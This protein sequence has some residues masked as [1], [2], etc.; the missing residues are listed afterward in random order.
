MAENKTGELALGD[1]LSEFIPL[2]YRHFL[3]AFHERGELNLTKSQNKALMIMEHR[4][5]V[6]SSEL[7]SCL[8]MTK[9]S[10]TTLL[11]SLEQTG[12]VT[13]QRDHEDRRKYWLMLTAAGK[14]YTRERKKSMDRHMAEKLARLSPEQ[15]QAF[16][17]QLGKL[18]AIMKLL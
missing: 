8:D 18:V 10:L 3:S 11:D 15:R 12:L 5:T 14:Q 9:A 6:I 16:I 13:R 4:G 17:V 1:L 7:G 2:F